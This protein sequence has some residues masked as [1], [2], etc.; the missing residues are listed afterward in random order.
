MITLSLLSSHFRNPEP[1]EAYRTKQYKVSRRLKLK[2]RRMEDEKSIHASILSTAQTLF[3][4]HYDAN[5][6]AA[7]VVLL[8]V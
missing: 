6:Y 8:L 4:S 1:W 7:A 5:S 2:E 3:S